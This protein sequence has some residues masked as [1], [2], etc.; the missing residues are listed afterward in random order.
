VVGCGDLDDLTF[1]RAERPRPRLLTRLCAR[2]G[3]S[4]DSKQR[5]AAPKTKRKQ[6]TQVR[7][8]ESNKDGRLL[9]GNK[10]V[11]YQKLIKQKV[12]ASCLRSVLW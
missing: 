2:A 10:D 12:K 7:V 8:V 5:S 11:G 1:L 6:E 4:R 3:F 9:S